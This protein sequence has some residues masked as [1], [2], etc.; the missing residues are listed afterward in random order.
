MNQLTHLYGM[1][2]V[3][4]G[5]VQEEAAGVWSAFTMNEEMGLEGT[6]AQ[7]LSIQGVK[8]MKPLNLMR[9]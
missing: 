8:G 6:R 1:H 9:V 4:Q 5:L 7:Q 2:S 3:V